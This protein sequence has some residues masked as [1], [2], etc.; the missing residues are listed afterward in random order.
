MQAPCFMERSR[1]GRF[2][3]QPLAL[4]HRQPRRALLQLFAKGHFFSTSLSTPESL[5][6]LPQ[7]SNSDSSHTFM[8]A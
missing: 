5:M 1:S 7:F 8:A 3:P 4:Q 6:S 2:N